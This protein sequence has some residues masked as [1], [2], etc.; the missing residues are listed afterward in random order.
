MSGK[1]PEPKTWSESAAMVVNRFQTVMEKHCRACGVA[2]Y[3]AASE[4]L[5]FELAN[6]CAC[7]DTAPQ[8][9]ALLKWRAEETEK[10]RVLE[11]ERIR[12]RIERAARPEG[13][14]TV[15]PPAPP[16]PVAAPRPAAPI[17]PPK[18]T[19]PPPATPEEAEK[20]AEERDRAAVRARFRGI[21]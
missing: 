16:R 14:F 1:P 2:V 4:P 5:P 11:A 19:E 20:R 18:P 8:R 9:L 21:L 3:G 17:S 6:A 10:A 13:T 7:P 15:P 12:A